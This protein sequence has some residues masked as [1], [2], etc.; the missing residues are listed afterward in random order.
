[1]SEWISVNERLPEE[2]QRI[3]IYTD[4]GLVIAAHLFDGDWRCDVGT[5]IIGKHTTHWMPLPA[6]PKEAT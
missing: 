6:P 2:H 3:L 1:M 4:K 5:W